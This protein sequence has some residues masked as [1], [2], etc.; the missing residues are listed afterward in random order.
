MHGQ[1][2]QAHQRGKQVPSRR[3]VSEPKPV[4]A[5]QSE[6]FF[7]PVA[8]ATNIDTAEDAVRKLEGRLGQIKLRRL[9][10]WEFENA[11]I[12]CANLTLDGQTSF[13]PMPGTL[14]DGYGAMSDTE[15]GRE[16]VSVSG[17]NRVLFSVNLSLNGYPPNATSR[18]LEVLMSLAA[19]IRITHVVKCLGQRK[20]AE[21]V[22]EITNC[23][24]MTQSSFF[25]KP[26]QG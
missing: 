20:A 25:K 24:Q 22:G 14:L 8:A 21:L 3:H 7:R 18:V 10:N 6:G 9:R 17:P 15:F 4:H 5:K 13:E 19:E 23:N 26:S 12:Q 11:L 16:V 1:R 2:A